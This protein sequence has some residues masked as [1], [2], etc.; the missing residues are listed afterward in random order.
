MSAIGNLM[1]VM[2]CT[3]PDI[4][5][6]VRVVNRYLFNPGKEHWNAVKWILKNL[7][8]TFKLYLCF[9]NGK[10]MLYR[11]IDAD[12]TGD[13]DNKKS[14]SKYLMIFAG[15]AV[16]WQNKLKN[17]IALSS[18]EAEYIAATEAWKETL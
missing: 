2:V 13:L 5:H 1:Y 16:S 15:G 10:T 12:M 8:G 14:T 11:Y 17:C 6:A 7:K 9:G 4:A 3:G 18:T